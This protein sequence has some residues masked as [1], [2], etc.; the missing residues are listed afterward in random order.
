MTALSALTILLLV[1]TAA[2]LSLC[3]VAARNGTSYALATAHLPAGTLLVLGIVTGS[4]TVSAAGV[5]AVVAS[6]LTSGFLAPPRTKDQEPE[7]TARHLRT[8]TVPVE[9]CPTCNVL[10]PVDL[11]RGFDAN[12]QPYLLPHTFRPSNS[13]GLRPALC[14]R[15]H[16]DL[17]AVA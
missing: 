5:V 16:R 13:G 12:N 8:L 10:A 17:L 4:S 11:A 2:N 7:A 1:T 6:A 15:V 14:S 3:L 9:M